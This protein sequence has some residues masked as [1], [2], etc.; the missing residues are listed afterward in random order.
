[1]FGLFV[2]IVEAHSGS[3]DQRLFSHVS[4]A[5]YVQ[6]CAD[7]LTPQPYA[8]NQNQLSS[9]FPHF[10]FNGTVLNVLLILVYS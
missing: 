4:Y 2:G 1:M 9:L 8:W 6:L 10:R 7:W 5:R 3:Y